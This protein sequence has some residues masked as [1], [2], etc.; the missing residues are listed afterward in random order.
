MKTRENI[1]SVIMA[2]GKGS[3]MRCPSLHKVC[4]PLGGVPVINRT[5]EALEKT[6]LKSHFI[7]VGHMAEQ[8][9]STVS[10][11][12]GSHFFCYQEKP[13]GTGSAARAAARL[14]KNNP[15]LEAV[16]VI[17]GD[18]IIEKD[19][20]DVLISDF[21][22]NESDLSF[23]SGKKEDFPG[24]G[25][26][27][28]DGGKIVGIAEAPD[29]AKAKLLCF[30]RDRVEG[31]DMPA[32]EA[33]EA[34]LSFIK[35]EGKAK[36]AL[37]AFWEDIERGK[38]V[39]KQTLDMRFR[40]DDYFIKVNGH[41]FPPGLSENSGWANLSVYLFRREAFFFSLD[42][43]TAGNSQGEEYL[44]DAVGLLS[45]RGARVRAVPVVDPRRVMSYNTPEELFEI[46][47]FLSKQ[48]S[49]FVV[50]AHKRTRT[51]LEWLRH[52]ETRS[53]RAEDFFER[54][55]GKGFPGID[56]KRK[57][58]IWALA[59]YKSRFG[60]TP[61]VIARAPGR[62]NAMGRHI[63]H[64]GGRVN[65]TAIDRD[66][67]CV[68][69]AR[70]DREVTAYNLDS[71][72]FPERRFT[73]DELGVRPGGCWQEFVD[74]PALKKSLFEAGGDWGQY[75]RGVFARLG[76]EYPGC[77]LKGANIVFEGD[78][79][80]G[81]GVSSSSALF[82]AVCEAA[83]ALNGFSHSDDELVRLCGEGE[84]YVGT[85]GGS[86]D[87]GAIKCS[88]KGRITQLEFFPFRK[89]GSV[90]FPPDYRLAVCNSGRKAHKTK[91]VKDVFNQRVTCY[92]AG[93]DLLKK[94]P[95]LE[96]VSFLRDIAAGGFN[97]FELAKALPVKI[98]KE[99]LL[100]KLSSERVK[101]KVGALSGNVS[102]LPLRA[103]TL[104]GITEC[105]RSFC[106]ADFL[107]KGDI[108][109]FG[110]LMNVSHDG[111]RV[112]FFDEDYTPVEFN[113]RF[114][115]EALD[116]RRHIPPEAEPG[117]YAC[118]VPEIDRMVDAALRAEGVAGAQISGAGLGG[119]MMVLVRKDCYAGLENALCEKYYGPL[120]L[121]PDMFAAE[122]V[123]GSGLVEF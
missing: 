53:E 22:E 62:I 34:A 49:A 56:E 73:L 96:K 51:P 21:Y 7:V 110:R 6:G 28:F 52:F 43:I 111:D 66:I 123:A 103:V 93:L 87:H 38:P 46:E 89:I 44:T 91:G 42:G 115:D 60:N 102:E 95:G 121:D 104:F 36:L 2:A 13:S 25:S 45:G 5:I 63:D 30:L 61:A 1:V 47:H 4:F 101:E 20:L 78:I 100:K 11:A 98:E 64:Q 17:A 86:A 71:Y 26:V 94:L 58:V 37:G 16:L 3:R 106:A 32:E 54:T 113:L 29:I 35:D 108:E 119:C 80:P 12:P 57:R 105:A 99:E 69:G 81:G 18:K 39:E 90:P 82:T 9:M 114:S 97:V 23:A 118:S 122:P 68:M 76:H 109:S 33:K 85:R 84:W 14:I 40:E 31:S 117:S 10:R 27:L 79:P 77:L 65:M 74:S 41:K 50:E 55:Y 88:E 24:A 15:S 75:V 48:E 83:S 70:E 59:G 112:V 67:Y 72:R 120:N 107:E 116:K 8:V 92:H 19:V